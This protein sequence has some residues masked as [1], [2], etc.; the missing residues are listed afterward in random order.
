MYSGV[1]SNNLNNKLLVPIGRLRNNFEFFRIFKEIY[2]SSGASPV[3][4]TPGRQE[5]V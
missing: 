4:T 1:S 2:D 3:S 5:E